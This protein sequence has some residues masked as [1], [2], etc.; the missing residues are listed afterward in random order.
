MILRFY[1]RTM[2]GRTFLS[3]LLRPWKW[4]LL[5]TLLFTPPRRYEP[6]SVFK[7][8]FIVDGRT[9]R[10]ED[11]AEMWRKQGISEHE[12]KLRFFEA[13]LILDD[14]K[15]RPLSTKRPPPELR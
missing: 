9:M 7:P 4:R 12:I 2:M 14:G 8:L 15:G 11:A 5:F 6:G 10:A 13:Y 1:G 3:F